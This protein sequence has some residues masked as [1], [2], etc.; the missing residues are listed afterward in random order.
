[1][2]FLCL[3][4][5]SLTFVFTN[6]KPATASSEWQLNMGGGRSGYEGPSQHASFAADPM[7]QRML[8]MHNYFLQDWPL[9]IGLDEACWRQSGPSMDFSDPDQDPV[10]YLASRLWY[11]SGN[12]YTAYGADENNSGNG[13]RPNCYWFGDWAFGSASNFYSVWRLS[14]VLSYQYQ[15][16]GTP[17]PPPYASCSGDTSSPRRNVCVYPTV[18]IYSYTVCSTHMTHKSDVIA[19]KQLDEAVNGAYGM[20]GTT[21]YPHPTYQAFLLGD[22]NISPLESFGYGYLTAPAY[23]AMSEACGSQ[24]AGNSSAFYSSGSEKID[25]VFGYIGGPSAGCVTQYFGPDT[26]F[27]DHALLVGYW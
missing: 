24:S 12:G 4:V 15:C 5:V 10:G 18:Y 25:Y 14:D 3:A 27:T 7:W 26:Q 2:P 9:G 22:F 17:L 23:N 21:F 1:M 11:V 6:A 16:D 13:T 19:Y 8:L 20:A